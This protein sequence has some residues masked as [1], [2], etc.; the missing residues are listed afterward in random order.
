MSSESLL[1]GSQTAGRTL[2]NTVSTSGGRELALLILSFWSCIAP[3]VHRAFVIACE[4]RAGRSE[5]RIGGHSKEERH[6]GGRG[7][8]T[9]AAWTGAHPLARARFYV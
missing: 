6:K 4:T 1:S 2:W 3:A 8:V 9:A 5:E 7:R